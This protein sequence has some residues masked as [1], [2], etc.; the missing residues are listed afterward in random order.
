MRSLC[1]TIALCL[2][3]LAAADVSHLPSSY[4]PPPKPEHAVSMSIEQQELRGAARA[5]GVHAGERAGE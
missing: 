4:L 3:C 2:A 5:G 1:L